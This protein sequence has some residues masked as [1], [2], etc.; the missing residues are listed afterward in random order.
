MSG[1]EFWEGL[2]EGVG[3]KT[4][5]ALTH[6]ELA[7]LLRESEMFAEHADVPADEEHGGRWESVEYEELFAYLLFKFGRLEKPSRSFPVI[8]LHHR[9][10][11]DPEKHR[12]AMAVAADYVKYLGGIDFA[13][14]DGPIDPTPFMMECHE[15]HGLFG[16]EVALQLFSSTD[17]AV[18]G[19]PWGRV[20][21]VEWEDEVPLRELFDSEGIV[22]PK[23]PFLDQRFI[24][25]LHRNFPRIDEINWRK[26]EALTAEFFH[27]EGYHVELGAGRAD[28][29]V[30]ARL[31]K[32]EPAEG[33]PPTVIIQCKR[34]KAPVEQVVL[35]ALYADVKNEGAQSGLIA[36][37]SRLSP[38]ARDVKRAR[39]YPIDE[40]DRATLQT[41][42]ENMRRP[43]AGFIP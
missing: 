34:Q 35:K 17:A 27:R 1:R 18:V 32:Q 33:E 6:D 39:A 16:T 8:D 38:S 25:F 22:A 28:G 19:S 3:Y 11:D 12:I 10:K 23:G 29:G 36:T 9:Y 13:A 40:A 42:I 41:W 7:G 21:T 30:D 15:K 26:F 5:L 43:G 20:R 14:L 4:G 31:W 37:T 2:T 24:D